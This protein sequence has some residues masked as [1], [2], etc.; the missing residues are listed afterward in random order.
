VPGYVGQQH[1]SPDR[2]RTPPRCGRDPRGSMQEGDGPGRA[3]ISPAQWV[4]E[5]VRTSS[6]PG[7]SCTWR[8]TCSPQTLRRRRPLS[9]RARMMARPPRVDIRLRKPWVLARFRVFGWYVRFTSD[10]LSPIS[11]APLREN[12]WQRPDHPG[13]H[14]G[15]RAYG[16]SSNARRDSPRPTSRQPRHG[17]R[18]IDHIR[19]R[20]P[21]LWTM[22]WT[23]VAPGAGRSR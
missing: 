12:R 21:H 20:V 2:W 19:V 3:R 7:S 17:V 10:S 18:S 14:P 16:A 11:V 23:V 1:R 6:G 22:L 15:H 5:A 9:R 13:Q 8:G 4:G